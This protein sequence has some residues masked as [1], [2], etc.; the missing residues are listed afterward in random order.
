MLDVQNP[1][2]TRR[3]LIL[4]VFLD[5]ESPIELQMSDIVIVH[6]LGSG[7]VVT[8]S[9]HSAGSRIWLDFNGLTSVIGAQGRG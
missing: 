7:I 6:E 3:R 8:A 4:P 2:S 5:V 9:H 1:S